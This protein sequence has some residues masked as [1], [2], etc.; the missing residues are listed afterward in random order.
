[1]IIDNQKLIHY[2]KS[3]VTESQIHIPNYQDDD[4]QLI[5]EIRLADFPDW[6]VGPT[7]DRFFTIFFEKGE[8]SHI[9]VEVV[10]GVEPFYLEVDPENQVKRP[11]LPLGVIDKSIFL[12]HGVTEDV[13]D[14]FALFMPPG[15]RLFSE[16]FVV[17]LQGTSDFRLKLAGTKRVEDFKE[18]FYILENLSLPEGQQ[19]WYKDSVR[20]EMQKYTT[21]KQPK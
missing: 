13:Y 17:N 8:P 20:K 5:T 7:Y 10:V 3:I 4:N 19:D 18:L 9:D 6:L 14:M 2:L 15:F 21:M 1:M 16:E 12:D 11:G